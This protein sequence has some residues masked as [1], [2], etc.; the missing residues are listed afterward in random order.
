MNLLP[1]PLPLINGA[2][3]FASQNAG[4]WGSVHGKKERGSE[5][6]GKGKSEGMEKGR[7]RRRERG[8]KEGGWENINYNTKVCV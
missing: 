7:E 3:L 5:G 6:G 8:G 4:S 2:R 1:L